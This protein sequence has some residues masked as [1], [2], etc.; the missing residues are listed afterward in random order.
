[1]SVS[2][3]FFSYS[4]SSPFFGL[5]VMEVYGWMRTSAREKNASSRLFFSND[6]KAFS[7]IELPRWYYLESTDMPDKKEIERKWYVWI[8]EKPVLPTCTWMYSKRVGC[9]FPPIPIVKLHEN[10]LIFC[11]FSF[12]SSLSSP[13]FC[14]SK[15][16]NVHLRLYEEKQNTEII[17]TRID[18]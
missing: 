4:S 17:L 9:F 12:F 18:E 2:S 8:R 6:S 10:K 11:T 14:L 16:V 7:K 3:V 5:L 1:M 13:F 15:R